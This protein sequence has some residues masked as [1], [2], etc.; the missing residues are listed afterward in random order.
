MKIALA[1]LLIVAFVPAGCSALQAGA[2]EGT[3]AALTGRL[4][5]VVPPAPLIP[6]SPEERYTWW[7]YLAFALASGFSYGVLSLVKGKIRDIRA[8]HR[9]RV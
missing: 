4:P 5:A 1:A 3:S 8:D 2:T 9:K 7:D 6:P